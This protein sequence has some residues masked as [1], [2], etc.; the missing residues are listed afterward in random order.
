MKVYRGQYGWSTTAHSKTKEGEEIKYYL[1]AQFKQGTEPKQDIEG[2]LIFREKGGKEWKAF[3]SS[4]LRKGVPTPKIVLLPTMQEQTPL[5]DN[6][7]KDLFHR[8]HKTEDVVIDPE[9]LPF[10]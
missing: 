9:E 3:F 7:D 2:E 5:V 6:N 8:T 10:Y 1:D 4:Y